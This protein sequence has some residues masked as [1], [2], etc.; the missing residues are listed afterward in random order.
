LLYTMEA[1]QEKGLIHFRN[2][3]HAHGYA[4]PFNVTYDR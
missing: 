2:A 4:S 3:P 1:L